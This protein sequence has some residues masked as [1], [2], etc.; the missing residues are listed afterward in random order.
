MF[1]QGLQ[2]GVERKNRVKSVWHHLWFMDPTQSWNYKLVY[3]HKTLRNKKVPKKYFRTLN[4]HP[5][6]SYGR[7]LSLVWAWG[8]CP[9]CSDWG[10]ESWGFAFGRYSREP[11]K[12]RCWRDRGVWWRV[13]PTAGNADSAWVWGWAG[14]QHRWATA[15]E[16]KHVTKVVNK[17]QISRFPFLSF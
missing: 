5:Q 12:G 6:L 1:L 7:R 4:F 2:R 15:I 17:W 3:L 13:G 9:A 10:Q 8:G 14:R 16:K 11:L